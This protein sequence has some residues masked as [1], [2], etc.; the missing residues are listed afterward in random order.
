MLYTYLLPHFNLTVTLRS[1]I[2]LYFTDNKTE[3]QRNYVTDITQG[4]RGGAVYA[5]FQK[6]LTNFFLIFKVRG[7]EG[8]RQG[9]KHQ[10]V[11]SHMSPTRDQTGNPG[12]CP[13]WKSNQWPFG[14]F[15]STQSTELHQ[16]GPYF[17]DLN[18]YTQSTRIWQVNSK[19]LGPTASLW[20]H[21]WKDF[22]GS[23]E[24]EMPISHK[25]R[26]YRALLGFAHPGEILWS[27]ERAEEVAHKQGIWQGFMHQ[28][29][30]GSPRGIGLLEQSRSPSL[31]V[32]HGLRLPG[33]YPCP[34]WHSSVY[35]FRP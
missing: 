24:E 17:R 19:L 21:H 32:P 18:Y 7:R 5:T 35:S 23:A 28:I 30:I 33:G 6:S 25:I 4:A 22:L 13:D 10:S 14:S 9:E 27:T 29:L 3:D 11:A 31:V 12:M 8:E 26:Q 20:D 16:P 15:A 34:S 1:K 2:C